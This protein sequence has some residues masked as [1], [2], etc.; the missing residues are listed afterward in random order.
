MPIYTTEVLTELYKKS[1]S[2]QWTI[3]HVSCHWTYIYLYE[4]LKNLR[5]IPAA[6][7]RSATMLNL[8]IYI[9]GLPCIL[10]LFHSRYHSLSFATTH[11]LPASQLIHLSVNKTLTEYGWVHLRQNRRKQSRIQTIQMQLTN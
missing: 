5:H 4:T 11:K 7:S 1:L 10:S 6:F 9:N 3:K 8:E 2:S